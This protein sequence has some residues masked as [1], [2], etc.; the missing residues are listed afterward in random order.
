[1]KPKALYLSFAVLVIIIFISIFIGRDKTR[2]QPNPQLIETQPIATEQQNLPLGYT[3]QLLSSSGDKPA[4]TII[5]KHLPKEKTTRISEIKITKE[6]QIEKSSPGPNRIPEAV[7]DESASG[8]T[9]AGKYPTQ[10][11]NNEMNARGIVMY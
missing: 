2:I 1:M 5:S 11:E 10:K 4:I 8:V 9:K 6:R 7:S 3:Q